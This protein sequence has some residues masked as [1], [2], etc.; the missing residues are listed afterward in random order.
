MNKI[1]TLIV[2]AAAILFM[3]LGF[4]PLQT[5]AASAPTL[6]CTNPANAVDAQQCG[7]CQ[8]AGISDKECG[9]A[10]KTSTNSVNTTIKNVINLLSV[11]AGIIAVVMIIIAGFR[12][13]TGGGNDQ[14]LASAKRTLLYAIIGLVIVAL[15]QVIARFTL[16][17]ATNGSSKN[18]PGTQSSP[19][20]PGTTS[21]Q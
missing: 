15:A 16:H 19:S 7:A 20:P 12:Y 1:K 11:V 3:M 14:A 4:L 13:T 5:A 10:D 21:H 18:P 2:L 17:T 8:A 9:N 6:D